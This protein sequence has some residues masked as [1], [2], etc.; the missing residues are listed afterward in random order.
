MDHPLP[1]PSP[2]PSRAAAVGA[3]AVLTFAALSADLVLR[4]PVTRADTPI[5]Q[6]F[7]L[8]AQP[9]TTQLMLAIS[10]LHSTVALCVFTAG[11]AAVLVLLGQVHWLPLLVAIVPGGL[12]LNA[13]VKLAFQRARPVFEHPLVSLHTF[14]FPSGHAAG[15]TVWWGFALVLWFAIEPRFAPRA[16]GCAV[17]AAMV[18]VTALSRVYLG[19]HY[20]SDVLAGIAEGT[21]WVVLC[22]AA[23]GALAPRRMV[24]EGRA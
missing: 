4:G 24:G 2:R 13:L 5:S 8:H 11:L 9:W 19:A 10:A 23:A 6:W 1:L 16:I 14:S 20:P 12:V 7:S 17:A 18:L 21:F 15:A 22:C 3:L